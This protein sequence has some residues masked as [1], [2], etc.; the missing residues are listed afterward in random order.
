VTSPMR[1]Y[2][3][4]AVAVLSQAVKDRPDH[5]E[6]FKFQTRKTGQKAAPD[7][8]AKRAQLASWESRELRRRQEVQRINDFLASDTLW[9][10]LMNVR[11][12]R[13]FFARNH[14]G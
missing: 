5:I 14:D 2:H 1:P 10:D 12:D 8:H 7:P 13:T 3:R 9:H 6:P 11:G 4:L